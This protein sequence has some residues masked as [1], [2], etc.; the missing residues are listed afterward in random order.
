M[1]VLLVD[2]S[3]V[4]RVISEAFLL[5]LGHEVILGENGQQALE[6]YREH[7]PDIILMDEVMPVMRGHEAAKAIREHEDNWVPIIFLSARFTAEDI[8]AGIDAGGDDYLAKPLDQ[9]VLAAKMKAMERISNMRQRLIEVSDELEAAN[10]ELKRLADVDGLTGLANR[11]YMDRFLKHEVA[12]C[13][14]NNEPLSVVMCDIDEFK[15]YND[16]YGHL[17]GDD[18]IRVI[19]NVL[20][21]SLKRATDLAARFGGE[22]FALIL[23]NTTEKDA[24]VLAEKIR[25]KVKSQNIMHEKSSVVSH[26]TLSMGVYNE[27]PTSMLRGDDYLNLADKALYHAK[28]TGRNKAVSYRDI[29]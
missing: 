17:K 29:K 10:V 25:A 28:Q 15:S 9:Q 27:V 6:L 5:E 20:I 11:R 14:R 2:D 1:K 23:P 7:N 21:S 4:D 12:R 22:E 3:P 18:C 26:V 24:K 8:S 19:A 16:F 13:S